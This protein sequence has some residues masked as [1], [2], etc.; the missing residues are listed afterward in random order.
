MIVVVGIFL[1]VGMVW[2]LS[3]PFVGMITLMGINMV[4]P[5]ELYPVYNALH[6][7]RVEAVLALLLL[8]AKGQRF[9]YPQVTKSVLYF[10][11]ACVASVPLAF[12]VSNALDSAEDF[13]K[14]I[15]IHLLLVA[16][17][18]TRRRLRIVLISFSLL[19]GYLSISSLSLYFQGKFDHT[20]GVDR[21]AG[22]TG[23]SNSP[24]T[25]GLT[26]ATALPI[27]YLFTLKPAKLPLRLAMWG[28]IGLSVWTLLLT[29][30]RGSLLSFLLILV[31]A[32]LISR[33][34]MIL[35][36]T[37][38]VLS[39]VVWSVLPQQYK[40]RYMTLSDPTKEA[41]TD[42]SYT[43][44][45]LSWEGGWHMFLHNPLTG[46]G[47]GDY[48]D[49][50]GAKYWPEPHR[51]WL[52]AHSLYFKILGELGLCGLI[53]FFSFVSVLWKTNN[54]VRKRL[55]EIAA[56][57]R[58]GG[59]GAEEVPR[60]LRLLPTASNLSVVGLLYCGYA[61]HDLYRSTWYFLAGIAGAL[62]LLTAQELTA[63][64]TAE[65][66][67]A[68]SPMEGEATALELPA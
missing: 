34:R 27:M 11:A 28:V 16:V 65:E 14:I 26:I 31:I 41:T 3:D 38:A 24:D 7:E 33:K 9:R 37:I 10:F 50:N 15:V 29:G 43:N 48:G 59:A 62:D 12:W 55:D 60:W 20:M 45:L 19:V 42:M 58:A 2:S 25:L 30:S 5:G 44:R 36:P 51:I 22:L 4:Q 54:R 67:P 57:V 13:G 23:A 21:I 39:V 61:Y 46:I 68:W 52:D 40:A 47:I 49:A 64:G 6:V 66:A 35:I 8:F 18:L 32:V 53:T 56:H 63:M 17:I 1:L